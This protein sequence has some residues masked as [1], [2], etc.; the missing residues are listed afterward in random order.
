MDSREYWAKREDKAR[1]NYIRDE[2]KRLKVL[3]DLYESMYDRIDKEINAFYAKYARDEGI[4]M[5]EARRRADNLD[6]E[7]YARKA[8]KY[9]KERNFSQQANDEM[10]LYNLT[11]KANRLELLKANIGLELVN[12]FEDLQMEFGDALT[13]RAIK[14]D[15][16]QAGIL[17]DSVFMSEKA[18]ETLVNASFHHATY[19]ERIWMHQ[20][21]LKAEI[22]KQ[23]RIGLIQGKNP[24]VLARAI[25]DRF[26]VSQRDAERLMITELAR[27]QSGVQKASFERNGYDEY[28]F[29]AEPTACPI[30]RALHGKHFKVA[31]MLP[32]ENCEPMHPRCKCSTAAYAKLPWEETE[33]Q[34]NEKTYIRDSGERGAG[35]VNTDLVNTKAYH[36]KFRDLS[37][38]KAVNENLYQEAMQILEDRNNTEFEDIVAIDARTGKRIVKNTSASDFGLTHQCGFTKDEQENLRKRGRPYEVLH[39]HPNSSY[40]SRDDIKKLFEREYQSGS[41]IAC[42]NGNVYRMEKLKPVPDIDKTIYRIYSDVKEDLKGYSKSAIEDET[43]RRLVKTLERSG[44]MVFTER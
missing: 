3:Q 44:H 6:I 17:G 16:R 1:R 28:E 39:N 31:D 11:M 20:A 26:R 27:V 30:C 18:A 37:S 43:S 41:T 24:K 10:K 19:S 34:E 42:H 9:V 5:A 4:T 7:A 13:E 2:A 35:H 25:R 14:E 23:L 29:I 38:V 15:Q 8:K 32:G 33:K 21:I 36:D 12:G 40:P 22:D